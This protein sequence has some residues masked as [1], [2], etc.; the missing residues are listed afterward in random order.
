M[1]R[2]GH[3]G[4]VRYFG[5]GRPSGHTRSGLCYCPINAASLTARIDTAEEGGSGKVLLLE[6]GGYKGMDAC[7]MFVSLIHFE[8][9]P[10]DAEQVP[11]R[12]GAPL[13]CEPEQLLGPPARLR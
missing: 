4:E 5:L 2:E 6:K 11:S 13:L 7:L 9:P 12:S 3:D 10:T 8:W 1:C